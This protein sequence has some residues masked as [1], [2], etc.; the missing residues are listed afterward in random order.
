MKACHALTTMMLAIAAT[1]VYAN[2]TP[3]RPF[4]WDSQAM[5]YA[6]P[7]SQSNAFSVGTRGAERDKAMVY[8][9]GGIQH[10]RK[11]NTKQT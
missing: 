1:S 3:P 7:P 10:Q 4:G 11:R 5:A 6:G 8:A 2:G 9:R